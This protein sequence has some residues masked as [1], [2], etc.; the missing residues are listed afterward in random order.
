MSG[1]NNRLHVDGG[2]FSPPQP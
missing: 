1:V 2:G